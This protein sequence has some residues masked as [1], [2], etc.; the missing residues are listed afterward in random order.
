MI[1]PLTAEE[2]L[3]KVRRYFHKKNTK[4]TQKKFCYKCRK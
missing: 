1:G 3:E 4:G 2:R